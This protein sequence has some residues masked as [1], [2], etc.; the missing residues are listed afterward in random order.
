MRLAGTAGTVAVLLLGGALPAL[1]G[2]A[3]GPEAVEI[4]GDT[5]PRSLTGTPE[6]SSLS[7]AFV[8]SDIICSPSIFSD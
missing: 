3:A 7:T 5:V 2:R 6:S 8:G 1:P 4:V